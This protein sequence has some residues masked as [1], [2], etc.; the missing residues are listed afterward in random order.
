MFKLV[1]T[2]VKLNL[3]NKIL[4][5]D[6]NKAN[7]FSID[8]I[9]QPLSVS[10][11]QASSGDEAL[12]EIL[13]HDFAVI[14]MD[15]EM[16][17]L[18]GYETTKLIHENKRFKDVPIVMVTARE[19]S[20]EQYLKAYEA[21]AV[22]FITK[23]IEPIILINKVKQFVELDRQKRTAQQLQLEHEQSAARLQA[24]L[25]SAGEG[26]LGIDLRGNITFANPKAAKILSIEQGDL[27]KKNLQDFLDSG[28]QEHLSS[29][30]DIELKHG[31]GRADITNLLKLQTDATIKKERWVTNTGSSFYVEFSCELTL[32]HNGKKSG[33]VLMFQNVTQRQEIEK[34]LVQLANFDPLTNLAN[35]AYFHDA[36]NR[37]IARV[38][39]NHSTLGLLYLDLDH[40]KNINDTL[41][42]DAGDLL[43]QTVG[44]RISES[45]RAGDLVARLGGD[46]FAVILH[47]LKSTTA[48]SHIAEKIINNIAIP[49]NLA[50]KDVSTSTSIGIAIYDSDTMALDAFTKAAD[51]AMYVAKNNGRNNFQF[52][53]PDMQKKSEEKNNIQVSLHEAMTDKQLS[54]HYQP[55]VDINSQK[56]VG[57]EALIRWTTKDGE[58]IPPDIFIP[59]AEESGQILE[60][61]EW[62]FKEV[63]QQIQTWQ[64]IPSFKNLAISVNVSALQFKAGNFHKLVKDSLKEFNITPHQLEL[65]LTETAIMSNP[66]LTI[67]ELNEIHNLGVKISIDDF[68]TGYSSLNYLKRFPID[69]LKIDRCFI[70]DIGNNKYDEEIIKVMVAIGH[71]MGIKVVAEGV[72]TQQQLNFLTSIGCDLGQGYFFSRPLNSQCSTELVKNISSDFASYLDKLNKGIETQ[73][74]KEELEPPPL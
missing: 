51:T 19:H 74:S 69:I 39:R 15:V 13:Q 71:T 56:V 20:K 34:H 55:K 53:D 16:P 3:D 7:R 5:V 57:M 31:D 73:D 9:L 14:L 27:L 58:S 22:D 54:M 23:P 63:C 45:V 29:A 41:G 48:A 30:N 35:R 24:M 52:F 36:L 6:D 67:T 72:E 46:E 68:G 2:E 17:G 38:K 47:D 10:I 1:Y 66:E 33:G 65:E 43:L 32:D 62:V 26:I 12:Q 64:K 49:I 44:E 8:A 40:F 61:G 59:I 42:H 4:I 25:N 50:G 11:Y 18:N 60:L 37:S 21:G 28:H 70:K